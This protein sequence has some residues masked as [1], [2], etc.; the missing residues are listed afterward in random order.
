M[1]PTTAWGYVYNE[2]HSMQ[3]Q[4]ESARMKTVA[5]TT[6]KVERYTWDTYY[7]P[8]SSG[9]GT[10]IGN[11]LILTNAHVIKDGQNDITVTTYTGESYKGT[12]LRV[13]KLKDLA[14]LSFDSLA[15]GFTMSDVSLYKGKPIMTIG[16][17]LGLP[18]WSFSEGVVQTVSGE[19]KLP[20]GASYMAVQT[21]AEVLSGNSGG[22][23]VDDKGEL[24]G[25][26]R[27]SSPGYSYAVP[28]EDIKA[29]LEE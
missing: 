7:N 29:F 17:P 13:D 23:L 10:M 9:T 28:M 5:I 8:L 1:L 15:D 12:L 11:G 27:A 26:V 25:I 6:A 4:L 2:S 16:Q 3:N 20:T 19:Y 24:V 21:D 18:Q 14:L 22:P